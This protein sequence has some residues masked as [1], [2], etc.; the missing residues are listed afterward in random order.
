MEENESDLYVFFF[1]VL[2]CFC[3]IRFA[4]FFNCL[5]CLAGGKMQER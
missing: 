4:D 3:V 5:F 2:V 1:F